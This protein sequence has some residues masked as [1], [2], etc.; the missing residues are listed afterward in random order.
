[1]SLFEAGVLINQVVTNVQLHGL[2]NSIN[3]LAMHFASEADARARENYARQ[4]L[5]DLRKALVTI[6]A[7][8]QMDLPYGYYQ[9]LEYQYTMQHC[10]IS[11]HSFSSLQEKEYALAVFNKLNLV[12]LGFEQQ[13]SSET[14]DDMQH[15]LRLNHGLIHFGELAN[16]REIASEMPSRPWFYGHWA[17]V[18]LAYL[19]PIQFLPIILIRHIL[20]LEFA[21][22][23]IVL[24]GLFLQTIYLAVH[25]AIYKIRKNAAV[26]RVIPK[27]VR[28]GGF[29]T[30]RLSRADCEA[31]VQQQSYQL[32]NL[33]FSPPKNGDA[34][35][36]YRDRL[37]EFRALIDSYGLPIQVRLQG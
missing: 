7:D 18:A 17:L 36:L 26:G 34:W 29:A 11:E 8:S 31:I 28:F 4:L 10:G 15:L 37:S 19:F 35:K 21:D 12:L 22:E 1:M 23:A 13:L 2:N 3:W 20:D 32:E 27:A 24:I 5:F 25:T 33:G 30:P 16:W 14:V 9:T 6:E